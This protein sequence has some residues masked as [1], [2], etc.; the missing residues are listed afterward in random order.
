[1]RAEKG[2]YTRSKANEVVLLVGCLNAGNITLN[3]YA[4]CIRKVFYKRALYYYIIQGD[5]PFS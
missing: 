4:E 5:I 3:N 2:H 1:M